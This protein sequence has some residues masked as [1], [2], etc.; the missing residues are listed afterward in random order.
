VEVG[1]SLQG[2]MSSWGTPDADEVQRLRPLECRLAACSTEWAS[3][4]PLVRAAEILAA[5]CTRTI[6]RH[7][8]C[9]RFC[10]CIYPKA[11]RMTRPPDLSPFARAYSNGV[12]TTGRPAASTRGESFRWMLDT[13]LIGKYPGTAT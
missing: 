3:D 9:D 13:S 2:E 7:T 4:Q 5:R 1:G 6:L 8:T 12:H 10:D 11:L